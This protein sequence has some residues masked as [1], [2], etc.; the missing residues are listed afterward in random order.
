MT[1]ATRLS[2]ENEPYTNFLSRLETLAASIKENSSEEVASL[3]TKDAFK[4]NLSPQIKSYLK[5]H[6]Q[7]NETLKVQARFLD[8]KKKHISTNSV[9]ALTRV[10]L[11]EQNERINKL[12]EQSREIAEQITH[13]TQLVQTSVLDQQQRN[14]EVNKVQKTPFRP[15]KR[16]QSQRTPTDRRRITCL[17]CG[18]FGHS[19]EEC[20]GGLKLKCH[21]CGKQGH[22]RNVCP[23]SKNVQ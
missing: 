6:G 10:D 1:D 8:D 18:I 12:T 20:R 2:S 14:L 17:K 7:L 9:N 23:L 3:Y 19:S 11:A 16:T 15:N 21:L 13:L 5:D 22:L 4:R